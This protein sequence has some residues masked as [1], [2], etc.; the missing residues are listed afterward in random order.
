MD[1]PLHAFSYANQF[2]KERN[3]YTEIKYQ[4]NWFAESL[5]ET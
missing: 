2:F 5:K 3:M 4:R 1:A